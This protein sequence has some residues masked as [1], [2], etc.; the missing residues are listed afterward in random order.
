MTESDSQA[1]ELL[2]E[3]VGLL[4]K[5]E[6]KTG[7]AK[8][9]FIES[10]VAML[11]VNPTDSP[12][13]G[14]FT[15]PNRD[16]KVKQP[17]PGLLVG[18]ITDIRVKTKKYERAY[19]G[20][21]ENE[22]IQVRVKPDE[23]TVI[24]EAGLD[25]GWA[26]SF[27]LSAASLDRSQIDG[28]LFGITS[29]VVSGNGA[30]WV[31]SNLYVDGNKV[32]P[33]VDEKWSDIDWRP[34]HSKVFGLFPK[35]ENGNSSAPAASGSTNSQRPSPPKTQ[36]QPAKSYSEKFALLA[37]KLKASG[38]DYAYSDVQAVHQETG[39]PPINTMNSEQ[40][41]QLIDDV[42]LNW[43]SL[44]TGMQAPMLLDDF[45]QT[46]DGATDKKAIEGWIEFIGM[47]SSGSPSG[48][49]AVQ[50]DEEF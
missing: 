13:T 7:N 1:A 14:W 12:E 28:A 15:I 9:G 47:L 26:R 4:K 30:D 38:G 45:R 42:L 46:T 43:G 18:W 35:D 8:T 17:M 36:S 44:T 27:M 23:T 37:D 31:A 22:F 6:A 24:V 16:T 48:G 3:A 21:T 40:A 50:P 32:S 5:I 25:S 33:I 49:N 39:L 41:R 10:S 20:R 19:N 2:L 29:K 11:Y 34:I